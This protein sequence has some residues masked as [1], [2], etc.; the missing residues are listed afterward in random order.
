M[1]PRFEGD[2]SGWDRLEHL[3]AVARRFL[4]KWGHAVALQAERVLDRSRNF[5]D[6]EVDAW[7]FCTAARQLGRAVDMIIELPET[8]PQLHDVIDRFRRNHPNLKLAR[9]VIDHFDDYATGV[10]DL[11][12]PNIRRGRR[13]GSQDAARRFE[14]RFVVDELSSYIEIDGSRIDIRTVSDAVATLVAHVLT[15]LGFPIRTEGDDPPQHRLQRPAGLC[16]V[17]V[18]H[19]PPRRDPAALQRLRGVLC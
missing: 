18:L 8:P 3:D 14:P 15:E 17:L 12:H 11:A 10:G 4:I 6:R 5:G 1:T 2:A 19:Q 13:T 9:D 16:D 7:Q